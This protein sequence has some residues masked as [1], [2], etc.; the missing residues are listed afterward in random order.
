MKLHDDID[1]PKSFPYDLRSRK[2]IPQRIQFALSP[3]D[4][5]ADRFQFP[6]MC[7]LG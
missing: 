5:S 7:V 1:V 4:H 3:S 2:K 6:S